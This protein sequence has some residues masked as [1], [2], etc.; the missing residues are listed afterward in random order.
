MS[1]APPS[2]AKSSVRAGTVAVAS[3]GVQ[4]AVE[5]LSRGRLARRRDPPNGSESLPRLLEAPGF[6]HHAV[7]GAG[8]VKARYLSQRHPAN[9]VRFVITQ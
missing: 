5:H 8:I 2:I 1:R 7:D 9:F 4:V 3:H 6:L